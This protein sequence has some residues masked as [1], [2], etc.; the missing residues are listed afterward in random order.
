MKII[1]WSGAGAFIV[2]L[3]LIGAIG[4]LFT[5]DVIEDQLEYYASYYNGARVEID[6][7]DI[8]FTSLRFS[9]NRLQV[10][11]VENTMENLIET[12]EATFDVALLPLIY[13]NVVVEDMALN[14]VQTNTPRAEDGKM[15]FPEQEEPDVVTKTVVA[16]TDRAKQSARLAFDDIKT[17]IN[18]DSLLASLNLATPSKV[19]S[20]KTAFN[21]RITRW[22]N[23]IDSLNYR[24]YVEFLKQDV[25]AIKPDEIKNPAQAKRALET[26][27]ELKTGTDSLKETISTIKSRAVDDVQQSVSTVSQID[28]WIQQDIT[29]AQ[30]AAKLPDLSVQNIGEMLFGS[31]FISKLTTY[32]G[33]A[34]Q[35]RQ[36]ARVMYGGDEEA[37][38]ARSE[39]R[40][41]VFSDKYDWPVFWTKNMDF[42]GATPDGL[43]YNGSLNHFT[44]NQQKIDEITK[45][46]LKGSREGG[47]KLE[48]DGSFDYLSEKRGET[49]II[50][51]SGFPLADVQLS[52][53]DLLPRQLSSGLG[54]LSANLQLIKQQMSGKIRFTVTEPVFQFDDVGTEQISRLKRLV[55][56]A[57]D[58]LDSLVIESQISSKNGQLD[59]TLSSNLDDHIMNSLQSTV[60]QEIERARQEIRKGVLDRTEE[61]KQELLTFVDQQKDNLTGNLES[62]NQQ[63]DDLQNIIK[64]KREELQEKA[65]GKLKN[66]LKDKIDFD[67]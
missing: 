51:Y 39:G 15:E 64:T 30:Q 41:I 43:S 33:Y 58:N 63:V 10:T 31:V 66:K 3:L 47:A 24:Q 1:R 16:L 56:S 6:D 52:E 59:F 20:A 2:V 61:K 28:E 23:R 22:N 62:L 42:S 27:K 4:Y 13:S 45:I 57:V 54:M 55:R 44:S 40:N 11:N 67:R 50:N 38:P 49:F 53:S 5:D 17:D 18:T 37:A 48:L 25:G 35:A 21:Q 29:R 36:F 32:L 26:L 9:W 8:S 34:G 60:S 19:D 65:A 12:G 7:F 14:G 46:G